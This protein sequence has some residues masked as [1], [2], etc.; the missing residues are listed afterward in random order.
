MKQV[1]FLGLDITSRAKMWECIK[2]KDE[3][4]SALSESLDEAERG[5]LAALRR[6]ATLEDALSKLESGRNSKGR[7]S[8][9]K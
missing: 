2:D 9:K 1:K 7:F 8:S 6:C 4:I 5:R 3:D